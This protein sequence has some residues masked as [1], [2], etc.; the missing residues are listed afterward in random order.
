MK[1]NV[2]QEKITNMIK[3]GGMQLKNS[4]AKKKYYESETA[5]RVDYLEV[6]QTVETKDAACMA[7]LQLRRVVNKAIWA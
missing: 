7:I 4:A 5:K 1:I 3:L 6:S 2:P